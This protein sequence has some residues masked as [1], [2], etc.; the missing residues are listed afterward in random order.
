VTS[1]P[2]RAEQASLPYL[3]K[4]GIDEEMPRVGRCLEQT[5]QHL[6]PSRPSGCRDKKSRFSTPG[7]SQFLTCDSSKTGSYR[8][9]AT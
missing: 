5:S 7:R 3:R 4:I 1:T 9:L 8:I 2:D 6:H